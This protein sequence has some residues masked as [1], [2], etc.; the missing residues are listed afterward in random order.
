MSRWINL[1]DDAW[2]MTFAAYCGL[3]HIVSDILAFQRGEFAGM[4]S[5]GS[6]FIP[7]VLWVFSATILIFIKSP[8]LIIAMMLILMVGLLLLLGFA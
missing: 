5:V 2:M 7:Y 4:S 6:L 8:P 1:A 3:L